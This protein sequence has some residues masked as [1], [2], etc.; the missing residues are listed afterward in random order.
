MFLRNL[1]A[2]STPKEI[3]LLVMALKVL[4]RTGFRLLQEK[5][6]DL[7]NLPNSKADIAGRKLH[8]K[9][10]RFSDSKVQQQLKPIQKIYTNKN[11]KPF[12]PN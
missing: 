2:I 10:L 5:H 1:Y 7:A 8:S 3:A 11:P 6:A 12:P 4:E 9:L